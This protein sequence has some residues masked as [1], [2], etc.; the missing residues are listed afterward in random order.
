MQPWI[1][2]AAAACM[3]LSG[4]A[5]HA[6]TPSA[7]SSAPPATDTP[8]PSGV[9]AAGPV[10]HHFNRTFDRVVDD[11]WAGSVHNFV[12]FGDHNCVIVGGGIKIEKGSA[13]A[14]WTAQSPA[15]A[16]LA[17]VLELANGESVFAEGPSPLTLDLSGLTTADR[18][19]GGSPLM[20]E[21]QQSA[22]PS[23]AVNQA[24]SL[25]L[26]IDHEGRDPGV[27]DSWQCAYTY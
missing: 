6:Q 2:A 26:S 22:T 11:V 12:G 25:T 3:I 8:P 17:V 15:A 24:V 20:V 5:G 1:V 16:N 27:D 14:T 9:E 19:L 7:S 4:C 13:V 10:L 21:M 18:F 23:A